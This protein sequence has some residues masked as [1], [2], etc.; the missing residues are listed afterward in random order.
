MIGAWANKSLRGIGKRLDDP[1]F[2]PVIYQGYGIWHA[3]LTLEA[4]GG[5]L[6]VAVPGTHAAGPNPAYADLL[7]ELAERQHDIARQAEQS[8]FGEYQALAP[9]MRRQYAVGSDWLS[10]EFRKSVPILEDPAQ[11]WTLL[12]GGTITLDDEAEQPGCFSIS[13]E[14][15]WGIEYGD[16]YRTFVNWKLEEEEAG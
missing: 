11:I 5:R 16:V 9:E 4:L 2:G 10:E 14:C 3:E 8:I 6:V 1:V 12:S 15:T 13:W 7:R